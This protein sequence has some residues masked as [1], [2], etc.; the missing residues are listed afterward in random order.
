MGA[1]AMG[2]A[3]VKVLVPIMVVVVVVM[4]FVV[5]A[6]AVDVTVEMCRK[7]EQNGVAEGYAESILIRTA[8]RTHPRFCLASRDPSTRAKD[9]RFRIA[10]DLRKRCIIGSSSPS[11]TCEQAGP[12][13][14]E[15]CL[16]GR[17]KSSS[18]QLLV[19]E[20]RRDLFKGGLYC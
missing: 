10:N 9:P 17:E 11:K 19:Y 18:A 5:V 12:Q 7:A 20:K 6:V 16:V 4:T 13:I 8:S 14:K 3:A 1:A 2:A 15:Q